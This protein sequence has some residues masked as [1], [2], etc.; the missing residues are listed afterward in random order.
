MSAKKVPVFKLPIC[1]TDFGLEAYWDGRG[2][3]PAIRFGFRLELGT[4]TY[5]SL[6]FD[7]IIATRT[8]SEICCTAWQ[9]DDAYDTLVEVQNS[10]W[11]KEILDAVSPR[12]LSQVRGTPKHYMIYLDSAGCFEVLASS[13]E[14]AESD[15]P[16]ELL[17]GR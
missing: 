10:T 4:R 12:L 13:F 8:S 1:S 15:H 11:L 9:I 3:Y 5:G 14:Y 6:S 2:I 17:P 7:K 16:S